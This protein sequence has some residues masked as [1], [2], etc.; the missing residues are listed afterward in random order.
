MVK[1]YAK[2]WPDHPFTFRIPYQSGPLVQ[3]PCCTHHQTPKEIRE[4]VFALLEGIPDD[5]WVYWA[6]DDLYPMWLDTR[7][8]NRIVRMIESGSGLAAQSDC[9]HIC[10]SN[11]SDRKQYAADART[12]RIQSLTSQSMKFVEVLDFDLIFMNL[13]TKAKVLRFFFEQLPEPSKL[14]KEMDTTK[15]LVKKPDDWKFHLTHKDLGVFGES[16][17]RGVIT[18]NCHDSMKKLD[19]SFR[20][21]RDLSE[22]KGHILRGSPNVWRHLLVRGL[23]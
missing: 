6:G 7:S 11:V 18:K 8:L 2:T 21:D 13:F 19:V 23:R 3:T 10:A 14:A 9:I 15:F 16:S 1:A 12:G 20:A 4:T 17:T 22:I 5:E